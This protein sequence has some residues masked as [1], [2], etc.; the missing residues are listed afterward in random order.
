MYHF[1]VMAACLV[2]L[3]INSIFGWVHFSNNDLACLVFAVALVIMIDLRI[4]TNG[5]SSAFQTIYDNHTVIARGLDI[6][7]AKLAK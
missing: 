5:L 3:V 2:G 7:N 4:I 6:I 1:F